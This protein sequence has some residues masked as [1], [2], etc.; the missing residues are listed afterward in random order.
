M[1]LSFD[2]E[3]AA[4]KVQCPS[5]MDVLESLQ[6]QGTYL[7]TMKAIYRKLIANVLLNGENSKCVTKVILK[8]LMPP[9]V[10][11]ST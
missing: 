11:H 1:L 2:E 10:H 9:P 5:M 6:M 8:A 3:I 7:S 4:D